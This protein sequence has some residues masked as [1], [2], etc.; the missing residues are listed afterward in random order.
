M[1]L[2]LRL[3]KVHPEFQ[4]FTTMKWIEAV[5]EFLYSARRS[6]MALDEVQTSLM[7]AMNDYLCTEKKNWCEIWWSTSREQKSCPFAVDFLAL[8]VRFGCVLYVEEKI[9]VAESIKKHPL[10][11]NNHSM[12]GICTARPLLFYSLDIGMMVDGWLPEDMIEVLLTYGAD[13]NTVFEG[14]SFWDQIQHSMVDFLVPMHAERVLSLI[15]DYGTDISEGYGTSYH[16]CSPFHQYIRCLKHIGSTEAIFSR[17]R[18]KQD[19]GPSDFTK[20]RRTFAGRRKTPLEWSKPSG[21]LE[22]DAFISTYYEHITNMMK[23]FIEH[24]SDPHR[25]DS[26]GQSVLD[27]CEGMPTVQCF[28]SEYMIQRTSQEVPLKQRRYSGMMSTPRKTSWTDKIINK[29]KFS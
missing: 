17:S 1:G 14:V 4:P 22:D 13:T 11:R 18:K 20:W 28:L 27:L 24:G 23:K 9:K 25:P 2:S 16:Q 19:F 29:L 21:A 26:N 15:L 6:E 7:E 10:R 12:T 5:A 8:A 3:L